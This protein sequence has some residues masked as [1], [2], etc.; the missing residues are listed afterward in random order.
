MSYKVDSATRDEII[1]LTV[2]HA[3][4]LD[5]GMADMLHE[6]YTHDGELLGLPPQDLIGREAIKAWGAGRVLLARTSRHVE[7]NHRVV[8]NAGVLTCTLLATVYRSDTED[9]T[10]TKPFM[11]GDYEDIYERED[12][13]WKIRQ[14]I[15]RKSFRILTPPVTS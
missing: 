5:H 3:Y 4:R 7:T 9:M 12:G 6:L 1:A 14:R 2:E 11:I 13:Q 15:I 10:N 8:W